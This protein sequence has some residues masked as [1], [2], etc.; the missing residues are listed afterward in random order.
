MM[1]L[2]QQK[3]F[4]LMELLVYIAI[5]SIVVVS[6]ITFGIDITT[7]T[8][9]ARIQTHVQQTARFTMDRILQEIRSADGLNVGSSNFGSHP[10]VLSLS[11]PQAGEDPTIIDVNGGVLEIQRGAGSPEPLTPDDL[12]VSSLVFTNLSFSGRTNNIRVELTIQHPNP[13]NTEVFDAVI[14]VRGS[15]VI[16]PS[17]I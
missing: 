14:T 12:V 16:R 3:G 15:A 4:T 7:S 2:A 6:F 13:E 1:R 11:K 17:E 10:G 8:Q 5:A 9:K